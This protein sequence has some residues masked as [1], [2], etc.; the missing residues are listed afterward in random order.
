MS[1]SAG[2]LNKEIGYRLLLGS[3]FNKK[4]PAAEGDAFPT[5]ELLRRLLSKLQLYHRVTRTSQ[6]ARFD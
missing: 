4:E 5:E 6:Q 2:T 3:L 1:P